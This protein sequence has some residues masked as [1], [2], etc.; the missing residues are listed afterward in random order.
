MTGCR[1]AA[2]DKAD[3]IIGAFGGYFLIPSIRERRSAA[4]PFIRVL[5]PGRHR[6]TPKASWR[7]IGPQ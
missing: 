1:V 3:S 5:C 2:T 4:S 6:E 7:S